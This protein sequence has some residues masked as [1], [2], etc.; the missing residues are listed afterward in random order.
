MALFS[1]EFSGRYFTPRY[2]LQ[3]LRTNGYGA[4]MIFAMDPY[5]LNY[6]YSQLPALKMIAEELFDDELEVDDNFYKKDW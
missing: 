6:S 5:R 3:S 2:N 4:H 1:Q